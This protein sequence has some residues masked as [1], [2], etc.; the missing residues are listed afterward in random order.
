MD[1]AIIKRLIDEEIIDFDKLILKNYKQIGLS[2][3]E[4]F[5]L[6]ELNNQKKTGETFISPSKLVKKLTISED[7]LIT[8]LDGLMQKKYLV[9]RLVIVDGKEKED[10]SFEHT[11]INLIN[12]YKEKI[13]SEITDSQKVYNTVEEEI[14]DLLEQQFQKQLKPLEIELI[15]KWVHEDNYSLEEIKAAILDAVKANKTSI[16][17][18]DGVLLKRTKNTKT[19]AKKKLS[20]GKSEALKAFYDTWEQK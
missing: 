10:F 17:Y 11:I 20:Q 8:I 14:V 3:I 2:E 13:E 4:A 18:V 1:H 12:I 19:G 5:L 15:Q 16:S 6:I 9:I 7:K